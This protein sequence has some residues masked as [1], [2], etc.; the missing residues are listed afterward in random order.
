MVAIGNALRGGRIPGTT[1]ACVV[2]DQPSAAGIEKA[3]ALGLETVVVARAAG[4]KRA[5][6]DARILAVLRA[7]EV[8][9]VCLAGYMRLL[10]KDFIE[11]YKGRILN[12]HPS[13]LPAFPGLD[14]QR[15][16]FEH[17]VKVTGATV[18]FVTEELDAGPIVTQLPVTIWEDD[19][20]ET[21]TARILEKEHRIYPSAISLYAQ[22][23]LRMEGRRV[24]I[25]DRAAPEE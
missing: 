7:R 23:R 17:G 5:Q 20:V 9:L 16:A 24:V 2:S 4:E 15:Q 8:D 14:A 25:L 21:L 11:A 13:L 18:H 19:T 3:R 6:H 10:S 12:I 22:G 1:I